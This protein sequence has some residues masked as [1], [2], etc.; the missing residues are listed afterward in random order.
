MQGS[1]TQILE[2]CVCWFL[3]CSCT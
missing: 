2:G 1:Q 3:M